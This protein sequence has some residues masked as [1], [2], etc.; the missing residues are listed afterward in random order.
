MHTCTY[1]KGCKLLLTRSYQYNDAL[2]LQTI[3]AVSFSF[4]L[5]TYIANAG[6]ERPRPTGPSSDADGRQ[7]RLSSHVSDKIFEDFP[8]CEGG[9]N[10]G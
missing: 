1:L 8:D 5:P 10:L 3:P 7:H 2:V 9:P 4:H 6:K